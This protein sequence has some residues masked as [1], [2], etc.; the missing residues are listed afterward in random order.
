MDDGRKGIPNAKCIYTATQLHSIQRKIIQFFFYLCIYILVLCTYI[1]TSPECL[2]EFRKR[3]KKKN[4]HKTG[5][6]KEQQLDGTLQSR[7]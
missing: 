2:K 1:Y 7:S 5:I 6:R 3:N 4:T